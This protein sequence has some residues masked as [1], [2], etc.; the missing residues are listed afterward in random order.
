MNRNGLIF[1]GLVLIALALAVKWFLDNNER[2]EIEIP[3]GYKGEARSNS[4][5]AA[6][7]FLKGMGIEAESIDSLLQ[8][9]SLPAGNND[10]MVLAIRRDTLSPQRSEELLDWVSAGGHLVMLPKWGFDY[11]DNEV[12]DDILSKLSISAHNIDYI[13]EDMEETENE[14]DHD[15]EMLESEAE[16]EFDY[17]YYD[18]SLLDVSF[19]GEDN[20]VQVEYD[21]FQRLEYQ[22]I[23]PDFIIDDVYGI[24][25]LHLRHGA[26]AV[27]VSTDLSFLDNW[28]IQEYNH[29]RFFWHLVH[30]SGIPE[31]VWLA[32]NDD[33]PPLWK[34]LWQHLH[35]LLTTLALLLFFWLLGIARRFGPIKREPPPQRRRILEHIEASGHFLWTQKQPDRLMSGLQRALNKRIAALHPG[36]SVYDQ[37][38]KEALLASITNVAEQDVMNLLH[39]PSM[40]TAQEFTRSVQRLEAIRKSL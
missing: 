40:N 14:V 36:W 25:L 9:D 5:L 34:W 27:T 1:T 32:H 23:T 10:V 30:L 26:G 7:R 33:M 19:P 28:N 20:I 17:E 11:D 29:A 35:Y 21:Q 15:E 38:E 39:K 8:V 31:K 3:I 37:E 12:E 4:L 22:H 18:S 2:R 16:F 24:R 13:E 6:R